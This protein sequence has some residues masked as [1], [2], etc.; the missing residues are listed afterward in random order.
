MAKTIFKE[1]PLG[2]TLPINNIHAVSVS[3]P[4][5]QDVI[6]YE[7]QTPAIVEQIVTAYPRFILHPYLKQMA[8]YIKNKYKVSDEYEVVVV[9]SQKA[10]KIIAD[11][12]FIHNS[13]E[14]KENFGIILVLKETCQLQKVLKFIQHVGCN[15]SSR[16][17]QDYLYDLGLLDIKH[18]E[19]VYEQEQLAQDKLVNNLAKAYK[20]PKENICLAP[21]GMNAVYSALKGIKA[22]GA[23]NARTI[24]VQFGWLY[25]DTMNVVKNHH[26]E[27]KIFYDIKNIGLLEEYLKT[28][29]RQVSSIITELPTNPLLLSVDIISLS[30]LCKKY[31]IP[32]IIDSTF[33][34]PYNV[35]LKPYADIM[36]ESLTKYACG[37]ADVLMGALIINES[38]TLAFCKEEFF[39]HCDQPYIKD[40]QRLAYQS[41]FYEERMQKINANA[42]KLIKYLEKAPFVKDLFHT[43]KEENYVE[44]MQ[45]KEAVGGVI[46]LTFNKDFEEV[47]DLLNF[48]KGPSLGTEFTLLMPYVYLAHYDFITC[49]KGRNFLKENKIPID[50][51]RIAVGCEDIDDIIFEFERIKTLI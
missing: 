10:V 19:I 17:A 34:S 9:S 43:L 4:K 25:L 47:Y 22:L 31:N 37:N 35:D 29:G 50:L 45:N 12:Y 16:F 23:K 15:L 3:M 33:A 41:S 6:D 14:V 27:S 7:E 13:I 32:L 1:I 20:Q 26:D 2:Q 8:L 39:K 44:V 18:E 46:S 36:I 38:S 48:P 11:K 21:S 40:I 28:Y 24:L 51:I 42:F 5:L 30:A 49:E